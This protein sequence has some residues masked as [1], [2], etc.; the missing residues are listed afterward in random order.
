MIEWLHPSLAFFAAAL[1]LPLCPV[2]VRRILLL[3]APLL[4]F[5]LLWRLSPQAHL[6]YELFGFELNLLRAD[7]L[8]RAFGIIFTLNALAA[9]LF[10][11]TRG[12]LG[13][14]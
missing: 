9:F 6:P 2:P 4:S 8:A 11:L 14:H 13:Q 5:A 1:L 3:A 10:A 7:A 12:S